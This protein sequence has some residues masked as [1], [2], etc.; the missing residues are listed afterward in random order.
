MSIGRYRCRTVICGMSR[1]WRLAVCEWDSSGLCAEPLHYACVT[2]SQ[3]F[4][5]PCGCNLPLILRISQ[6][7][8]CPA[9]IP[10]YD[11]STSAADYSTNW[12]VLESWAQPSNMYL[13][14]WFE[15]E[16]RVDHGEDGEDRGGQAAGPDKTRPC[17]VNPQP[18]QWDEDVTTVLQ[19][20]QQQWRVAVQHH[21]Q[22]VELSAEPRRHGGQGD[23]GRSGMWGGQVVGGQG[24]AGV[25]WGW[26]FGS[27]GTLFTLNE[28]AELVHISSQVE[29]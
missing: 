24:G 8:G 7:L 23:G 19:Q 20:V 22:Q 27:S 17:R 28:E 10:K 6:G 12:P 5:S 9:T 4:N 11:H 21:H 26:G 16:P 29:D 25:E 13:A 14:L 1:A 2:A 15:F 3:G 18:V